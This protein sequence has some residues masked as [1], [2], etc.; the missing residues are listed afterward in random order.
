MPLLRLGGLTLERIPFLES[1]LDEE[2]ALPLDVADAIRE[3]AINISAYRFFYRSGDHLVEGFLVEPNVGERLPCIVYNRGGYGDFGCITERFVLM[4][5]MSRFAEQ[6]YLV[7]ASQYSGCGESEGVDDDG[8]EQTVNDVLRLYDLLRHDARAD[9]LRIGMYGG[10]RGGMMTYLCLR[11]ASWIKA[12]VSVCG[13]ASLM[14]TSFRPEMEAH[15][16]E[17]FGGGVAERRARSVLEWV[18]ELPKTTPLLLLHG[19]ADWRVNPMD[20]LLLAQR[21]YQEKVPCRL[22]MYEGTDHQFSEHWDEA[23]RESLTWLNRFVR[24]GEALPNMEPHGS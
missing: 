20:S 3:R 23:E 19:T 7:I 17:V 8:G 1:Y 22:V 12:A 9:A 2:P 15:Y 10:S 5:G 6:G 4:S 18:D 11:Y 16:Q 24:D 21:C 13:V 14:D